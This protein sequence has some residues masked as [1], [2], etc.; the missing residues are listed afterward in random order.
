MGTTRVGVIVRYGLNPIAWRVR[1]AQ[2]EVADA[3]PYGYH[4]A[5]SS[6]DMEWSVDRQEGRAAL[7]WRMTVRH[8][9]G[10]DL[11]HVWRNRDIIARADVIWTHTEREHLA[12]ALLKT[13][14]PRRYRARTIA[15]SVW[16]W[17]LWPHISPI[18]RAFFARLLRKH[19]VEIVLSRVNREASQLAVPGRHVLRVPF[20]THFASQRV[21]GDVAPSRVLVV[22]NDR[23][24]DWTLLKE[25][26]QRLPHLGIDVISLSPE[27][28]QLEWP[29]NVT[30]RSLLQREILTDA[31]RRAAV[32]ALPLG[33]NLHA[34]GCTVAIEAISAGVP[35]VA[36]NA[37][38]I[39]EYLVD[40]DAK[41]VAVGDV[42]AFAA[43]LAERAAAAS[44][45]D[46]TVAERRG[47]SER[48]YV[49]RLLS[50]T[51]SLLQGTA[52]HP[53]VEAFAPVA[54][55]KKEVAR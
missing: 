4:W 27:V 20:G 24:R 6:T 3:T 43:A 28:R 25:V 30:V 21:E 29:D 42:T 12:V 23:H 53:A 2:G 35:V 31:Y 33:A 52:F 1:H 44:A 15:Q 22:G 32:V 45:G 55:P 17:D 9:L 50:I 47:L 13:L 7:W 39:D 18:R 5:E 54:L 11:V 19:D 41:L 40:A 38:G 8:A 26:A 37:G 36:T 49:N 10:F 34:S 14:F 48:D 16:L 46:P 51:A